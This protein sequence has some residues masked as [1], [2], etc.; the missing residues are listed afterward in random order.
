MDQITYTDFTNVDQRVGTITR[1]EDF[2]E[3]RNPSYKLRI[4]FG[5]EIGI[6]KSSAQ[7]THHYTPEDLIGTQVVAVV[8]FPAKQIW[9]FMSECLVTWFSDQDGH[10]ILARPEFPVSNGEKLH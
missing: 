8:N 9:P 4:D 7:I 1:A 3:A 6:K 10:I 5:A 2:E